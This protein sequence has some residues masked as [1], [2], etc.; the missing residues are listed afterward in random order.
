M[1]IHQENSYALS[2]LWCTDRRETQSR[3]PVNEGKNPPAY[4]KEWSQVLSLEWLPRQLVWNDKNNFTLCPTTSCN[5][6]GNNPT[7]FTHY[8]S[9]SLPSC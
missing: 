9:Q 5:Q 8:K 1:L 6:A 4:I 7:P 3:E 2:S